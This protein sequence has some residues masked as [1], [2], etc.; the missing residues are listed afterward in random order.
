MLTNKSSHIQEFLSFV[1][2]LLYS[3]TASGLCAKNQSISRHRGPVA[4]SKLAAGQPCRRAPGG[5]IPLLGPGSRA[6]PQQ[7]LPAHG[8]R[9][10]L[11]GRAALRHPPQPKW[12]GEGDTA[13]S[14]GARSSPAAPARCSAA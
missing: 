1:L 3:L 7:L 2:F 6:M 5:N 4:T 14:P 11:G 13:A 12:Q 8:Q 9:R 10:G